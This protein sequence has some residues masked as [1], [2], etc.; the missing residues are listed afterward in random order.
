[1]LKFVSYY[2]LPVLERAKH[3]YLVGIFIWRY[4]WYKRK[5]Q[6]YETTKNSFEFCY[7]ISNLKYMFV[8]ICI[9]K[10]TFE[11]YSRFPGRENH[12]LKGLLLK[13]RICSP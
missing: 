13:E 11:R 5:S 10:S 9:D 1:M 8:D 12:I 4:W 6:K 3:L 2:I 7:T